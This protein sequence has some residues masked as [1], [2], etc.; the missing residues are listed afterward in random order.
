MADEIDRSNPF[1]DTA[2]KATSIQSHQECVSVTA[3]YKLTVTLTTAR[4]RGTL[5]KIERERETE[6]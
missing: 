2:G 4:E 1:C 5:R 6:R 3:I